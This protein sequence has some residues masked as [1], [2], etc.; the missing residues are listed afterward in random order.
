MLSG[1]ALL[2]GVS[3]LALWCGTRPDNARAFQVVALLSLLV[4]VTM[5]WAVIR[6]YRMRY[7][8]LLEM[9]D[10]VN[11][12]F[13]F[14]ADILALV[15]AK[16]GVHN[17]NPAWM[18]ITGRPVALGSGMNL[19]DAAHPQ[20]V[21][22]LRA[23]LASTV[24]APRQVE[25]RLRRADGAYAWVAWRMVRLPE[26]GLHFAIGRDVTEDKQREAEL[27]QSQKM[28]TIGQLTGGI[29]HDF[30]NLLTVIMGSLELLQRD[31]HGADAKAQRRID[32]AMAGGHRAAAL[33][34][35]L[36]AFARRQPLAPAPVDPN[37]LVAGMSEMLRRVL[38]EHIALHLICAP[39]LWRVM[40]DGHQLESAILNLAVNARDAMPEGGQLTVETRNVSLDDAAAAREADVAPG[41]YVMIAVTDTGAGMGPEVMARV[42]EPFFTTKP[43][44]QGTGL[45]LAQV[46][47]FTRQSHGH[48]QIH[49]GPGRGTVVRLY[50]PRLHG[51]VSPEALPEAGLAAEDGQGRGETVLLVEDEEVVRLFAAE[52]LRDY[53]YN[54][55]VAEN[56]AEALPVIASARA[57]DLLFTDM[58]LNGKMSG[59]QLAALF[60][61]SR[62]GVPVL[63]TTGYM[64]GAGL[65]LG[66]LEEAGEFLGKPFTALG[67]AQA[68][69]RKLDGRGRC[70]QAQ[71]GT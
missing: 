14:S 55:I 39:G 20:D 27:R 52:V 15:D 62:P 40:A 64:Y 26:T 35:R 11:R 54:V 8:R 13:R 44:G 34:Q 3:G 32:A 38:G 68:I 17:L 41:Q 57:V 49:S 12:I 58:V 30:N 5:A 31:L 60:A 67:L 42:F 22:A 10:E 7:A 66:R 51:E 48:V 16:G 50:L 25:T 6:G 71:S 45:G 29:A 47:G 61:E 4:M 28:E 46:H 70:S 65:N 1:L 2:A 9:H 19:L 63:F 56:A 18:Q 24:A 59:R 21:H 37:R 36:L 43:E 33:T 69:R 23:A 53:G